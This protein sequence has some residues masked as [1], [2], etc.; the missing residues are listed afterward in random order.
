MNST[1]TTQKYLAT[2]D[3]QNVYKELKAME[4][5]D[6]YKTES[7]YSPTSD[8]R[9]SFVDKHMRYLCAHQKVDYRHYISNLKLMT[10]IR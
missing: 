6:S 10:S 2:E 3:A 5:S 8:T 9:I 4:A 7:S 1:L